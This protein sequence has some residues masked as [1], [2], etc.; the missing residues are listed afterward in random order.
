MDFLVSAQ[1]AQYEF[2]KYPDCG[3]MMKDGWTTYELA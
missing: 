1:L 3:L 2:E